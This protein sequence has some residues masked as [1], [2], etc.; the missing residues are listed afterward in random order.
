MW[1]LEIGERT[2]AQMVS[3]QAWANPKGQEY[4]RK[5]RKVDK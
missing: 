3:V 4:G 5:G 2:K 1:L